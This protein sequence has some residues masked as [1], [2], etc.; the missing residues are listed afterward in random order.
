MPCSWQ[1]AWGAAAILDRAAGFR[2]ASETAVDFAAPRLQP[3]MGAAQPEPLR[4][5]LAAR[6]AHRMQGTGDRLIVNQAELV[7]ACG[8]EV[9]RRRFE[10]CPY[11][12]DDNSLHPDAFHALFFSAVLADRDPPLLRAS[13][14]GDASARK[15]GRSG[16]R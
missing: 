11:V 5:L 13:D 9:R 2:K 15:K 1:D 7:A 16:P 3:Q 4:V 12:V 10:W 6:E 8:F 14:R